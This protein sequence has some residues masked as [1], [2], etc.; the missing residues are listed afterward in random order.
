MVKNTTVIIKKAVQVIIYLVVLWFMFQIITSHWQ[1]LSDHLG[2]INIL[3]LAGGF[4]IHVLSLLLQSYIWH[5]LLIYSSPTLPF[6]SSYISYFRSII[7]RYIP[8]GIWVYVSRV[9]LTKK[10]GLTGSQGL[11]LI[12]A[13]SLLAVLSGC[14]LYLIVHPATTYGR[15]LLLLAAVLICTCILLLYSPQTIKRVYRT[16]FGRELE[17]VPLRTRYIG[18][19]MLLYLAQWLLVG[20]GV[21]LLVNALTPT[22][23]SAIVPLSGIFAISWALGFAFLVTPSGL[24]IREVVLVLLLSSITG[25][26][27]A[28]LVSIFSR[29]FFTL[30]EA[31]HFGSSFIIRSKQHT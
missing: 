15:A 4:L 14:L 18:V 26:E 29:V 16:L 5:R 19:A 3:W 2:T 28:V 12:V 21:W 24:G 6:T 27:V 9:H 7:T 17:I 25:V 31:L 22:S 30:G 11:F 10:L 23:L 13:E 8:G 20:L 1:E